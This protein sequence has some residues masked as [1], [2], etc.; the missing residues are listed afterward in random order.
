MSLDS[1]GVP[2]CPPDQHWAGVSRPQGHGESEE[3]LLGVEP[4]RAGRLPVLGGVLWGPGTGSGCWVNIKGVGGQ[5]GLQS[6]IM[7]PAVSAVS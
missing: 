6:I 3:L 4:R 7:L 1:R 5:C 2:C